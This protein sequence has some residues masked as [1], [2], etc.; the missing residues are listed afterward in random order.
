MSESVIVAL[1]ALVGTLSGAVLSAFATIRA[2]EVEARRQP[3]RSPDE[4]ER[5]RLL[6]ASS[7]TKGVWIAIVGALL[8]GALSGLLAHG[9]LTSIKQRL[10]QN[11]LGDF[12]AFNEIGSL[13]ISN[14]SDPLNVRP[15]KL[16]KGTRG[17]LSFDNKTPEK[18]S[19]GALRISLTTPIQPDGQLAGARLESGDLPAYPADIIV[20]WVYVDNTENAR[21]ADLRAFVQAGVTARDG[22]FIVNVGPQKRITPGS[23]TPITWSRSGSAFFWQP[24]QDRVAGTERC[25]FKDDGGRFT[26][27]ELLISADAQDYNGS[28]Y[29][30]DASFYSAGLTR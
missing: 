30:D 6:F 29:V 2:A 14:V 18:G 1:L 9:V 16:A 15:W 20:I 17:T 28:I 3:G 13:E 12:R 26:S 8:I 27:I 21:N 5:L 25:R 19:N 10:S 22:A 7:R 4:K 24:G 11:V 23:W